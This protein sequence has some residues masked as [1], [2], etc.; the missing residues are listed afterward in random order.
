MDLDFLANL[1]LNEKPVAPLL[2]MDEM[3]ALGGSHEEEEEEEGK[4]PVSQTD[5]SGLLP[6]NN[7]EEIEE[8]DSS[9][10]SPSKTEPKEKTKTISLK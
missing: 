8:E 4:A 2:S 7:D 1:S 9:E 10:G 3:D 6:F 5:N